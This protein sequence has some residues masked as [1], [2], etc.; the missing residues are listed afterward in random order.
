[1]TQDTADNIELGGYSLG[2]GT[3]IGEF[4]TTD[5]SGS[6]PAGAAEQYSSVEDA[7]DYYYALEPLVIEGNS[8]TMWQSEG[9]AYDGNG[10]P[11]D[12]NE[13]EWATDMVVTFTPNSA[14]ELSGAFS[15]EDEDSC[16]STYNQSADFSVVFTKTSLYQTIKSKRGRI[17][18]PLF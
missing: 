7:M 3:L 5:S 10:D 8:A 11:S 6:C 13:C 9:E 2:S 4:S 15:I 14:T 18:L 1:M 12:G 16:D 17:V